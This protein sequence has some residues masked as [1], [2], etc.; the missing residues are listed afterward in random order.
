MK[1][2]HLLHGLPT[3]QAQFVLLLV[4][5]PSFTCKVYQTLLQVSEST[6]DRDLFELRS[7]GFIISIG[8]TRGRR[9]ALHPELLQALYSEPALRRMLRL[10]F[11]EVPPLVA[12]VSG[13]D[14]T[15]FRRTQVRRE[16]QRSIP[17]NASQLRL[18]FDSNSTH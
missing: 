18:E 16:S 11:E 4:D 15:H 5:R 6:A 7:R 3:R 17:E 10:R 2:I 13:S 9:Y 14:S 8:V 1:W 12:V